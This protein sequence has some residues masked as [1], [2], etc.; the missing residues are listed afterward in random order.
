MDSPYTWALV[1][2][3]FVA[4]ACSY[5]LPRAWRW[6]GLGGLSFFA[7]TLFLDYGN[8][9]DLHPF[10]SFGC[11]AVVCVAV[12]VVYLQGAGEE[13]ELGI[14]IAFLCSCFASLLRIGGFIPEPWVYASLQELAN[15]AALLW[16]TGSGI[17]DMI[18]R[19]EGSRFHPVYRRIHHSRHHVGNHD[20]TP[21]R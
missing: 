5:H 2:M 4:L 19:H 21:R 15:L 6:I 18:G 16:I 8:L 13:W 10:L 1:G 11:D 14:F 9:P 12:G 17:I 7:T 3:A 20:Q